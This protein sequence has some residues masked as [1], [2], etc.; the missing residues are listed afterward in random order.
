MPLLLPACAA[1]ATP[2]AGRRR[3][4]LTRGE[5]EVTEIITDGKIS[6]T[7]LLRLVA[8]V[9]R[10]SEHPL[11]EAIVRHAESLG[12]ESVRGEGFENV[13]GQGATAQVD[14]RRVAGGNLRLMTQQGIDL[15]RWRPAET[16][17]PPRARP[18]WSP[19]WTAAPWG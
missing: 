5:P 18:R 1:C 14:G 6:K 2:D 17:S 9:E 8:A 16:P 10:E 12:A 11:A 13:P 3:G 7:E 19:R 15:G 4:G